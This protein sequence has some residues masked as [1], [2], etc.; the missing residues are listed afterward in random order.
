MSLRDILGLSSPEPEEQE[1]EQESEVIQPVQQYATVEQM[2]AMV[3]GVTAQL[4]ENLVNFMSG[5]QHQQQ[6]QQQEPAYQ[7]IQEPSLDE[8]QAAWEEG[9]TRKAIQLQ[10]QRDAARD[11]RYEYQLYRLRQEGE[12][13]VGGVNEQL[14][15]TS[16]PEYKKYEKDVQQ[17]GKEIGIDAKLLKNPQVVALL[18]D[19]VKGRKIDEIYAER[20]EAERRQAN[21]A[22]LGEPTGGRAYPTKVPKESP[23]GEAEESAI[24]YYGIDREQ[25]AKKRGHNSWSDY[26]D[27][28]AA[29]K[30]AKQGQANYVPKWRRNK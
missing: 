21:D 24:R 23:I 1:V 11:Q 5:Q 13:W 2:Q 22:A 14:L 28:V 25:F 15:G 12:S 6:P 18:T 19:A 10:A 9:D 16:V 4:Q 26:E 29:Y 8:V 3:Q 7:P 27:T 30:S 20:Q 17:L